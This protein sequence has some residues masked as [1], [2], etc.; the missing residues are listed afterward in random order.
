MSSKIQILSELAHVASDNNKTDN[1]VAQFFSAFKIP[2]LLAIY[3]CVKSKGYSV[4]SLVLMLIMFRL[5]GKSIW[6]LQKTNV[7]CIAVCDDNT[8]YRLMNNPLMN[9]RKL[10]MGFAKQFQSIVKAKGAIVQTVK[11]FVVDDTDLEK[12]G[13]TIEFIGKIF[14]H[15]VRRHILGFKM[16][17]L[18]FWDGKSLTG[19]DFSLHRE[20]GKNGNYGMRK[21][22]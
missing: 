10:L 1:G 2:R 17:A 14:N 13:K 8:F 9:W 3:E 5:R 19:I 20:K 15:V 12:T 16:L 4:S 22:T 6:S 21:K 18:C 7:N 11:C